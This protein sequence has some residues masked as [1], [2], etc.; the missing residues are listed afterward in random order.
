M[1]SKN[2][3]K[4]AILKENCFIDPKVAAERNMG[5]PSCTECFLKNDVK[6]LL[7]FT[8][9]M[10][11]CDGWSHYVVFEDL[12]AFYNAFINN[13]E[14]KLEPSVRMHEYANWEKNNRGSAEEKECEEFWL[15]RFKSIPPSIDLEKPMIPAL[16]AA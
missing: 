11:V 7:I 14:P 9:Q 15:S 16:E 10:I 3:L 1:N 4:F 5:R 8:A 2:I 12:S 13:S 6:H